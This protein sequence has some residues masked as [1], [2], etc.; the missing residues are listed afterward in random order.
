MLLV[1]TCSEVLDEMPQREN[2][3][4]QLYTICATSPWILRN[5][6]CNL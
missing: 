2:K 5:G 6:I 1:R 4:H 3:R